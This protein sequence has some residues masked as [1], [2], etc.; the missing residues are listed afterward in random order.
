[1]VVVGSPHVIYT[2]LLEADIHGT[3]E[4]QGLSF[5]HPIHLLVWRKLDSEYEIHLKLS[6]YQLDSRSSPLSG[7]IIV[8]MI[9]HKV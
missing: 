3:R 9:G 5:T 7:P 1:M 2:G 8:D 4:A 6:G